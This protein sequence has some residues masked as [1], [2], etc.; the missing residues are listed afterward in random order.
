MTARDNFVKSS[1]RD[2]RREKKSLG[3]ATPA[4]PGVTTGAFV[5]LC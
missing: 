2:D 3:E 4:E 1:S 5:R